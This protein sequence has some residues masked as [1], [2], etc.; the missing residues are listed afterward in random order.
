ML[1]ILTSTTLL[2]AMITNLVLL[3]ALLITFDSGKRKVGVPV[4]ID[5][6]NEADDLIEDSSEAEES[7]ETTEQQEKLTTE[8]EV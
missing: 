3:P 4:L 5:S 2:I 7:L 6:Y 1:G 8:S